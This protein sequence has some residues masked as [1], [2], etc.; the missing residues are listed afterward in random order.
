MSSFATH[1]MEII[2]SNTTDDEKKEILY[3][4]GGV[5]RIMGDAKNIMIEVCEKPCNKSPKRGRSWWKCMG[6]SSGCSCAV[7][8]IIKIDN[9]PT[10]YELHNY[11]YM[12][13]MP[14]QQKE[15]VEEN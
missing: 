6:Y 8:D 13:D 3:H 7:E 1:A 2:N 11:K 5:G 9:P 14:S 15:E 12:W 4:F 10:L